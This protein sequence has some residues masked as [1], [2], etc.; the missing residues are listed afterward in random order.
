M[1]FEHYDIPADFARCY[2]LMRELRGKLL[3][4]TQFIGQ[5]QRQQAQAFYP[6]VGYLA[7]GLH[8]YRYLS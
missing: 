4:E 8:F 6:R 1:K 2:A 3:S 5:A 7:L